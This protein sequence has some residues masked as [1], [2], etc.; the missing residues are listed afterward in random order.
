MA[1]PGQTSFALT[2]QVKTNNQQTTSEE[3]DEV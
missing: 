2:K 1:V 3:P